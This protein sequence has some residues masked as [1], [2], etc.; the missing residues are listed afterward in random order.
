MNMLNRGAVL[1][2][3]LALAPTADAGFN[4]FRQ[5]RQPRMVMGEQAA[6]KVEHLVGSLDWKTDLDTA[7]TQAAAQD[8][9]VFWIHMLGRIDGST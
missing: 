2:L 1:A 8:K 4:R 6:Q 7:L 3:A 5:A 9:L